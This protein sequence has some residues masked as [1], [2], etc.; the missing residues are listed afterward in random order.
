MLNKIITFS[1]KHRIIVLATF[2]FIAVIGSYL[3]T[4]MDVDVFPDLTSPTVTILT[5]A[6]GMA[7]EEVEML[8]SFPVESALNGAPNVR[9]IRSSSAMGIS[10]VWVEF[11]WGTDIYTARQIVAEK[12]AM[13]EG[14]LPEGVENPL[15]A[16]ISSIMGEVMLLS[17]SSDSI[18]SMELR[19]IADWDIRP[20]LLAIG[21]VA[22]TIIIGGDYK[23]YQILASPEKMQYFNI[24]MTELE[25]A[26]AASTH[27]ASGGFINE[28]GNQYIVQGVGRTNSVEKIGQTLVKMV[29]TTPILIEDVAEVK[30]GSAQKIGDAGVNAKPSVVLVLMKQPNANTLKLTER[31]DATL[32]DIQKQLP[33]GVEVN[34]HIFR[35]SDFIQASINNLQNTLL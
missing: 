7:T 21:G 35:Q 6:H 25:Y 4:E 22:Q 10:I 17:L 28:Y 8:V 16:P 20:Q 31:I 1:L 2:T 9:R 12:L 24:S 3:A 34:T 33:P 29:G 14:K 5:E 27:N 13:V 11:E 18:S 19:T 32:S 23:Q 26:T 30:I 15:L